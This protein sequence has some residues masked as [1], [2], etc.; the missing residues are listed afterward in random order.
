MKIQCSSVFIIKATGFSLSGTLGEVFAVWIR[1]S[2]Q[3]SIV[4]VGQAV[5]QRLGMCVCVD[6]H[7]TH[8]H[9]NLNLLNSTHFFFPKTQQI[10]QETPCNAP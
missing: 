1:M 4:Y 9:V 10:T 5:K 6:I 2:E 8:S 3:C 7:V